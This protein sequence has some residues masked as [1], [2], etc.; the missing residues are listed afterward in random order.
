MYAV[1]I[2]NDIRTGKTKML[3]DSGRKGWTCHDSIKEKRI[4]VGN[5]N[6]DVGVEKPMN[7]KGLANY[8]G[9]VGLMI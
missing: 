5:E 6:S 1:V 7:E 8:S 2:L 3:P 9:G 4:R